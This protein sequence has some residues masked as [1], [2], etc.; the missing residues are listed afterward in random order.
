MARG[1]K[2]APSGDGGKET[3]ESTYK[4]VNETSETA[5]EGENDDEKHSKKKNDNKKK[6]KDKGKKGTEVK[7]GEQEEGGEEEEDDGDGRILEPL[8]IETTEFDMERARQVLTGTNERDVEAL[9]GML[10]EKAQKRLK[11]IQEK[12][13]AKKEKEEDAKQ[14]VSHSPV[15]DKEILGSV[16]P[17]R[18]GE[19][20]KKKKKPTINLSNN[21]DADY[22]KQFKRSL[23]QRPSKK[24]AKEHRND[25]V[26]R[27]KTNSGRLV[28]CNVKSFP[29]F[30]FGEFGVGHK[31]Y[32]FM[33]KKMLMI[34]SIM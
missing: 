17:I 18:K 6:N 19:G 9:A 21:A 34:L 7:E 5:I 32:F 28:P 2:V 26:P 12:R 1:A 22:I 23:M 14:Y 27:D 13:R 30:R 10:D 33:I 8:Q 31:A 4:K 3:K 16:G 20:T 11:K 15:A 25:H 29:D 24:R